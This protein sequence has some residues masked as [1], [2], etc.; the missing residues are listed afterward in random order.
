MELVTVACIAL[1][2]IGSAN[3]AGFGFG[4]H[5]RQQFFTEVIDDDVDTLR[6][7]VIEVAEANGER[8]GALHN[9]MRAQNLGFPP[10]KIV[11]DVQGIST[12]YSDPYAAC[13]V[14]PAL[15]VAGRFFK[16]EEVAE[17]GMILHISSS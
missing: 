16:L 13:V 17:S 10:G 14:F 7:K 15:K 6:Q 12:Q 3:S 8:E 1:N 5:R 2:R 11:F 4:R 9:L